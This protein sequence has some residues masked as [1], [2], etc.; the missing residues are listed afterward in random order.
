MLKQVSIII[1]SVKQE[2]ALDKILYD[3]SHLESEIIVSTEGSRAKSLNAGAAKANRDYLWFLHADS[4]LSAENFSVLEKIIAAKS[5][6]LN[7]FDLE[8][9]E[10]GLFRLNAFFANIRS[11]V[12]SLPYGDQGFFLSKETFEKIGKYPEDVVF[13]EDLLFVRI[14]KKK[15][16]KL[17]RIPSKLY[18]SARKY[19]QQGWLK[20]TLLRQVQMYKLLSQKI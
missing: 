7:Y 14:A 18:T 13:G 15:A 6:D 4:H 16:V 1:P 20:L 8:Y 3:L 5:N 19:K 12:F 17:N 9:V 10:P 11:Y 2:P